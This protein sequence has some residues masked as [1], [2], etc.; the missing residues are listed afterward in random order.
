MI[1]NV[2]RPAQAEA[3]ANDDFICIESYAGYRTYDKHPL[4][5]QHL[6]KPDVD[7]EKLGLTAL[8]ALARSWLVCSSGALNQLSRDEERLRYADWASSMMS[9]YGY[10][11]KRAL[12]NN[13]RNCTIRRVKDTIIL[14]PSIHQGLDC[15]IREKNDGIEDVY[16]PAGSTPTEIGVALRLAFDRCV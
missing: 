13:M 4:G 15:W 11:S 14:M 5:S 1:R 10:K 9:R 12:F 3:I 16:A 2:T 7:N 6:L 8:D